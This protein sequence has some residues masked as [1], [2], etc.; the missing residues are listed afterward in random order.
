MTL[1]DALNKALQI[2][3]LY[4]ID[5]VVNPDTYNNQADIKLRLR[6]FA[7]DAQQEISRTNGRITREFKVVKIE[8]DFAYSTTLEDVTRK[9]GESTEFTGQAG[10]SYSLNVSGDCTVTVSVG[11]TV[12]DTISVYPT[13]GEFDC[14]KGV[15]SN[16]NNADVVIGISS[17][18]DYLYKNIAIYKNK[19]AADADV[20]EYT[21]SQKATAPSDLVE[22]VQGQI[23][24]NNTRSSDYRVFGRDIYLSNT[25]SGMWTISYFAKP[26]EITSTTPLSYEFEV[27]A[28]THDAIPYKMAYLT[29]LDIGGVSASVLTAIKNEYSQLLSST[30]DEPH[31]KSTTIKNVYGF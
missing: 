20:P 13:S 6:A 12:V 27:P 5:G 11:G 22:Y 15:I 3:N 7:N 31:F 24:F 28:Q 23:Y 16:P 2:L 1:G 21:T 29:A 17:D 8:N 26:Q 30:I 10:Q 4:S 18:Y 9:H 25:S 19:Y 14:I